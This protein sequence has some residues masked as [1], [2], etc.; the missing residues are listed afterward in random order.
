MIICVDSWIKLNHH[1]N[2]KVSKVIVQLCRLINIQTTT[3]VEQKSKTIIPN[4]AQPARLFGEWIAYL[5]R[6]RRY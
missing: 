2:H 4:F 1:V 6:F 5:V 3:P